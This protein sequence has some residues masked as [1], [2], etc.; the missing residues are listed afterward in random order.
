[1]SATT[2]PTT[3]SDL[4][5]DLMNRVRAD[6]TTTA[7]ITLAKRYVNVALQDV[8]IQQNWPWA[9][10]R[11]VLQVQAPYTD[12]TV[13]IALA[14]RTTVTGTGTLW[15]TAVTGM[16]FTNVTAGG[17]MQFAGTTD[18]YGVATVTSDTALTLTDRYLGSTA[19]S[20]ATYT[21]YKD[22]YALAADF[23][24]MVDTRTFSNVMNIPILGSAD[25][26]RRFPRNARAGTPEVCTLLE[27]GPSGSTDTQPRVVFHPYPDQLYNLPYRYMTKDLAMSSAGAGQTALSAD[28]DEP[29]IPLR[30]RHV[31]CLYAAREWFRD[32]KDDQRSQEVGTEYVDLVK[33]MSGDSEPQRDRPRFIPAKSR[34]PIFLGRRG[35]SRFTTGSAFDEMRE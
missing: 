27:L 19:L 29:I 23:F 24:R 30:Y 21:F 32:R 31:L 9:E 7:Q 25:F 11:A 16:G 8:H 28:T 20:G 14:T 26:Y 10:R 3:Y 5:T 18:P 35:Q 13:A 17:K 12:G 34:Y 2:A 4:Y 15:N 6:T 22:E 1:M 33:R